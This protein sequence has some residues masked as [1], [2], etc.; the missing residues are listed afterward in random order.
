MHFTLSP[1]GEEQELKVIADYGFDAHND[2]SCG[3]VWFMQLIL[4]TSG[5]VSEALQCFTTKACK[6]KCIT[7]KGGT[8][9]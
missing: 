9:K 4:I 7:R 8:M 2:P 3:A 1:P 5:N 6:M